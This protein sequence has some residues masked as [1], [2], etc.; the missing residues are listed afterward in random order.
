[1]TRCADIAICGKP[2][3]R[4]HKRPLRPVGGGACSDDSNRTC[5]LLLSVATVPTTTPSK[6]KAQRGCQHNNK[7]ESR[8]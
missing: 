2:F 8:Q 5:C 6:R 1:M 4:E 7:P 3:A